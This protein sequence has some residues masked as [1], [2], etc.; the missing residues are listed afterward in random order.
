MTFS[1][2]NKRRLRY[3]KKRR[4]RRPSFSIVI[5]SF[6]ITFQLRARVNKSIRMELYTTSVQCKKWADLVRKSIVGDRLARINATHVNGTPAY[7]LKPELQFLIVYMRGHCPDAAYLSLHIH[8]RCVPPS[9][10]MTTSFYCTIAASFERHSSL[11]LFISLQTRQTTK[12]WL[13]PC[14]FRFVYIISTK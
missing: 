5:V 1:R 10:A 14:D 12:Y 7:S 11:S 4:R 9:P 6:R 2:N 13:N 3:N 8:S